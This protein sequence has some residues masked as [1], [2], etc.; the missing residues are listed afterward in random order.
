MDTSLKQLKQRLI[1][2][3][4]IVAMAVIFIPMLFDNTER[5]EPVTLDMDVPPKPKYTFEDSD[6]NPPLNAQSS[7]ASAGA[8]RPGATGMIARSKIERRASTKQ[9]LNPSEVAQSPVS[10]PLSARAHERSEDRAQNIASSKIESQAVWPT[11]QVHPAP[12]GDA[13]KTQVANTPTPI[14]PPDVKG[15]ISENIPSLPKNASSSKSTEASPTRMKAASPV[16]PGSSANALLSGWAV[17]VGSF[18]ERDNAML[19]LDKLRSS[20]FAAF[21]ERGASAGE[22]VFRVKVG[23]ELNRERAEA[24]QVR[25]RDQ[26]NL[27]GIVVSQAPES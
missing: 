6:Q 9:P 5:K 12:I 1:G 3:A 21:Q 22:P 14:A 4:V 16:E 27:P 13:G 25:L 18:S 15:P 2:A 24:L 26:Q 8:D 17:Q 20:G 23:P 11:E 7:N 19:L 10:K